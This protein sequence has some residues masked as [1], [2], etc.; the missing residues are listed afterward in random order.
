MGKVEIR[1]FEGFFILIWHST[2]WVA[3]FECLREAGVGLAG[4][5]VSAG[6]FFQAAAWCS[7]ELSMPCFYAVESLAWVL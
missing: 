2:I 1:S 7:L 6:V 5:C 4:W 3:V